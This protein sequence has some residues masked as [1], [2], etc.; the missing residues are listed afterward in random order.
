[1]KKEKQQLRSY[2]KFLTLLFFPSLVF[3]YP[4]YLP[5]SLHPSIFNHFSPLLFSPLSFYH[6]FFFIL[7]LILSP[8][9]SRPS[10][11]FFPVPSSASSF[12]RFSSFPLLSFLYLYFFTSAFFLLFSSS[13]LSTHSF[14]SLSHTIPASLLS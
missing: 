14:L 13:P 3:L 9:R 2:Q 7:I 12:L 6:L 5:R 1:M 11:L 8:S 4:S 10:Y